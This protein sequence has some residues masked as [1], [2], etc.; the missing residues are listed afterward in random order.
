[1]STR[2][3]LFL[4]SI[5][6]LSVP[7]CAPKFVDNSFYNVKKFHHALDGFQNPEGS[8]KKHSN[9]FNF[10]TFIF[11]RLTESYHPNYLPE[12]HILD[13]SIVKRQLLFHPKNSRLTW[14][15]HS[16]FLIGLNGINILTDPHFS[17]RASPVSF[18]GPKR[19]V[20]VPLLISELPKIDVILISHNHYDS[21]D[22]ASIRQIFRHSPDVRIIVPLGN[23]TLIQKWG[24][25]NIEEVDW[26][27]TV[28]VNDI[29]FQSTPAIHRSNRGLFD[30]NQSLWSGFL[31]S[32]MIDEKER[33]I[34]FSGDTGF[35][36]VF[37]DEVSPRVGPVDIAIIPIGAFLP[38]ELMQA[39][40]VS[41]EEAL[42]L[43]E[44]MGAKFAIPMH[45]GTFQLG[46]DTPKIGKERFL[47]NPIS[48][49][50]KLVMK[51][52]ETVD[53]MKLFY[54]IE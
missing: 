34:W 46:E 14:V 51:I 36:P 52:G 44:I 16:T 24:I 9:P 23:S 11:K 33:K 8:P 17:E 47:K 45:W 28:R 48:S 26:Y 6:I 43:A 10:T 3:L 25:N 22:E 49:V 20:P 31:I 50:K 18:G 38:R 19:I 40:H 7:G 30:T 4:F 35:G 5:V 21:L 54:I 12:N 13:K 37:Q 42:K 15:G 27:D 1:M 39:A 29:S 53:L 32:A 2:R 41:P